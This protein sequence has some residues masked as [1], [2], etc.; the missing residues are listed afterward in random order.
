MLEAKAHEA[1]A[2]YMRS[3]WLRHARELQEI[4]NALSIQ[5]AKEVVNV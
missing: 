2:E 4:R 3:I 5:E 1:K